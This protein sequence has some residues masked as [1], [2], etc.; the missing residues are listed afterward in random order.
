MTSH[1]ELHILVEIADRA[2]DGDF[3]DLA[4]LLRALPPT[5]AERDG[6]ILALDAAPL[7]R[8][9]A[10]LRDFLDLG[11][12]DG[13][14]FAASWTDLHVLA[15]NT[16]T[17]PDALI[18]APHPDRTAPT[19][20][21]DDLAILAASDLVLAARAATVW[22]LWIPEAWLPALATTFGEIREVEPGDHPLTSR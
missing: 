12:S 14:G 5:A 7:A 13:S 21:D 11:R 22:T 18:V 16:L 1:P 10:E 2:R 8:P 3:L 20:A 19:A 6:R 4:D 15:Q 9:S 17:I